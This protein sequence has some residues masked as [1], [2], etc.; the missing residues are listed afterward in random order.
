MKLCPMAILLLAGVSVAPVARAHGGEDH[1]HAPATEPAAAMA[2]AA[3][4]AAPIRLPDGGLLVPKATQRL[5]GL[6]SALAQFHDIPHSVALKG[7]II[8]DPNASGRVQAT[9][10][11]RIEP[12]P[13]GLP[14]LGQRVTKGQTL[15][16]LRPVADS[17]TRAASQA[18]L[19]EIVSAIGLAQ[20]RV[21]RLQQLEGSV[22]QK[23]IAA[24]QSELT[25]LNARKAAL[26]SG[27]N[28]L[29]ALI[30]PVAGVVSSMRAATGQVAEAR[31]TL[32]EIID[33]QKLWVE[34][35]A[36]DMELTGQIA[37]TSGL[38][39]NGTPVKLSYLGSGWQL[40]EQAVPLQFRLEPPLPAL[41]VGEVLKL[42]VQTRKN[43]SGVALPATSVVKTLGGET[44][45]WVKQ[46][47]ERFA[48]RKVIAQDLDN[49]RMAITSGL[50]NGERVVTQGAAL[51]SQIR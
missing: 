48:P 8:A 34:A 38:T 11:G 26:S 24:A 31:E 5:L 29:E 43:L 6:R 27:L 22:P 12:G 1:D 9:Q 35:V 28:Q 49:E 23:D 17:L 2:K 18:Q 41:S 15:A 45:V 20:Q 42:V 40:K 19:A 39:S 46:S 36:Y 13:H 37:A 3:P 30:A 50:K 7:H 32:F 44:M 10:S 33:P 25:G 51:L 47:A 16:Y 4:G 21:E 14:N